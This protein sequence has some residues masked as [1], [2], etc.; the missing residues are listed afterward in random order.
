MSNINQSE[1]I[2]LIAPFT[3]NHGQGRISQMV[4]KI[5]SNNFNV[6]TLSTHIS[7]NFYIKSFKSLFLILRIIFFI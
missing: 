6:K 1:I 7:G 3:K 4:K 5:I 2:L